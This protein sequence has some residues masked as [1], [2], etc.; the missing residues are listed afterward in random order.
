MLASPVPAPGDGGR[1]LGA[2]CA[3]AAL[4]L[5][6]LVLRDWEE[7]SE[8]AQQP[9]ISLVGS[10]CKCLFEMHSYIHVGHLRYF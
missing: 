5:C 3:P 1:V 2:S 9:E 10:C 6:P 7:Q 8:N 4:L